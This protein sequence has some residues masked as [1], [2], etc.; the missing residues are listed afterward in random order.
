MYIFDRI[1]A[2]RGIDSESKGSFLL[3]DYSSLHNPFLLPDMQ[4]AVDRL[5]LAHDNQEKIVVY[6]DYDIDGLTSVALL[7]DAFEK[8][9]FKHVDYFIP[10]RFIDGYGMSIESVD[11]LAAKGNN[12]IVTVDCGSLNVNEI[13]RA[14]ELDMDVIVTDHHNVGDDL[15]SAVAVVN[16]KRSDSEYPFGDLAGVGVAFKLIQALKTRLDGLDDGHEKWLLDLVALGTVCDVVSLVGENR[17]FAYWGMKVLSKTRRKGLVFLMRIADVKLDSIRSRSLGFAL[18]PRLNAAGRIEA[19]TCALELLISSDEFG[20]EEK[21]AYLDKLNYLRREEQNTILEEAIAQAKEYEQDSVLVVSNK[22]WNHGVV[23][24]VAAR[25]LEKYKKP[26]FVIHEIG[27]ESK[28]SARSFGDF[29]AV[30]AINAARDLITKGGGHRLAAGITLPTDNIDKFRKRL[31]KFYADQSLV[32]QQNKLLPNAD[33]EGELNEITE[34]LIGL[35]DQMEPFGNGNPK[36]II[37]TNNLKVVDRRQLGVDGKHIKLS[38]MDASGYIMKFVSFNAPD[39]FF[40]DLGAMVSV[41]Y[42]PTLNEWN[43]I[44]SIEGSILHLELL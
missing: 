21:A 6:G 44:H 15:P 12:L 35:I 28:G 26:T 24:I 22:N 41:W 1:L 4:K 9:G 11:D 30:D 43:G 36:P 7:L 38:L 31:N 13:L 8:L 10:N 5:V 29:S 27:E 25:L 20:A 18:G 34:E 16:P 2:A 37:K 42:H 3:P 39:D 32:D 17:V 23:G 33:T 14:R 40:I 19:A